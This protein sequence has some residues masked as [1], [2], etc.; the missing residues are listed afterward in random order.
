MHEKFDDI[1]N[2]RREYTSA[3][4]SKKT[5][6]PSP[7]T[8]FKRWLDQSIETEPYDPTAFSI[9]TVNEDG[10]PSS[11]VVL[12][13]GFDDSGFRFYTNYD[14][15]KGHDISVNNKGSMLFYWPVLERQIRINGVLRKTSSS[16]SEDYFNKRPIGSRISAIISHQSH[17][18]QDRE[19]LETLY[20]EEI[21]K[22]N[23]QEPEC[24]DYWGGYQLYPNY[25]EFWQGR[26]NRLHDRITYTLLSNEN[27]SLDRIAP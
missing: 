12:L 2:L 26:K 18:V 23:G 27:W 3:E 20:D 13:K 19:T 5:C 10:Q 8:Q 6:D 16:F 9:A 1:E 4:L 22:L 15:Q 17:P 7:F 25:F 11:R 24:P 21:K 14:S